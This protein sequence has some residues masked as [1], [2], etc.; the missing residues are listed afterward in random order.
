MK[1]LLNVSRSSFEKSGLDVIEI[2]A[3]PKAQ[4]PPIQISCSNQEM[5]AERQ[6]IFFNV[7]IRKALFN[8]SIKDERALLD[9]DIAP[10]SWPT[11]GL[12]PAPTNKKSGFTSITVPSMRRFITDSGKLAQLDKL[13]HELKRD[14]HRVLLYFQMTR[15]MDLME[16]YLTYRNYKYTRL[17][18]ST[19]IENRRDRVGEFQSDPSIFVFLL[20]TRAGD[21]KSTRLN[22]SH[23]G[24]SRMPSSA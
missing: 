1:N 19:S 2:C 10:S 24:E 3:V 13:L 20:S 23:S 16:E 14:D 18:G 5:E 9:A 22:S 15:M 21:R 12:L 4:A 8:P 7:A 11:S 6:N 17:D